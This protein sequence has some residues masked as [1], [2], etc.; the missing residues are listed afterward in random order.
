MLFLSFKIVET[1]TK[2]AM[3]KKDE[4]TYNSH[5]FHINHFAC[6]YFPLKARQ[7][8]V[9]ARRPLKYRSQPTAAIQPSAT[10]ALFLSRKMALM[11]MI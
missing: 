4:N 9:S 3:Y 10:K 11:S 5:K 8:F 2:N 7:S 6:C 1:K